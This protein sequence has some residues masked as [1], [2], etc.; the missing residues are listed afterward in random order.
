[1][2][3]LFEQVKSAAGNLSET[4]RMPF[5]FLRVISVQTIIFGGENSKEQGA[6]RK[7]VPCREA[8]RRRFIRKDAFEAF[9]GG[10][11]NLLFGIIPFSRV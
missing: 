2:L 8:G 1:M 7:I 6:R 5:R 4:A 11:K 9:P 10:K 3:L